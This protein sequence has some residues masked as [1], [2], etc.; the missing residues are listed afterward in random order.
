MSQKSVK[1][2]Q[3][4]F[5]VWFFWPLAMLSWNYGWIRL[6]Q[7]QKVF[8]WGALTEE[9]AGIKY[10]Y[11]LGKNVCSHLSLAFFFRWGGMTLPPPRILP[12]AGQKIELF[13]GAPTNS[14]PQVEKLSD[15]GKVIWELPS[16]VLPPQMKNLVL[17]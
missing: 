1:I 12:A 2:I 8:P 16:H 3:T 7:G 10:I 15:S 13:F 11:H 5:A 6:K 9:E 17:P 14:L 4:L